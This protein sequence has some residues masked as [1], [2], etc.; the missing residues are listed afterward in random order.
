MSGGCYGHGERTG[1]DIHQ[2]MEIKRYR[3][4]LEEATKLLEEAVDRYPV[5]EDQKLWTSRVRAWLKENI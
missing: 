5:E 2:R 4:R 1:K 3:D